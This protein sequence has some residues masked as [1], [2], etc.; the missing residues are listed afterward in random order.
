MVSYALLLTLYLLVLYVQYDSWTAH[1]VQE[2]LSDVLFTEATG[3]RDAGGNVV[4]ALSSSSDI[5]DWYST[6]FLDDGLCAA[7]L[8]GCLLQSG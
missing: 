2:G 6:V 1:F 7:S 4:G 5:I 3:T 8:R